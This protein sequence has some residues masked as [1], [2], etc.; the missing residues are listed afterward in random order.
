MKRT[1]MTTAY[2]TKSQLLDYVTRREF[3]DFKED[4]HAFK[5]EVYSFRDEMYEFRRSTE[6]RLDRI[7]KRFDEIKEDFR[8]QTGYLMEEMRDE[9]QAMKEY[10]QPLFAL[11]NKNP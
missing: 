8:I 5:E 2:A 6:S 10:I 7:D 11:L 4:F 3:L 9:R 1:K